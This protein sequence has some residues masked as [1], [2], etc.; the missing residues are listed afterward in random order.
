MKDGED[1]KRIV[2][3]CM[4]CAT[5]TVGP[6]PRQATLTK[7]RTMFVAISAKHSDLGFATLQL[8]GDTA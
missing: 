5:V 3:V 2:I 8:G 7:S 4:R 1:T 6:R